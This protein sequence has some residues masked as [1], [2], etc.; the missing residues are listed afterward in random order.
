M[1]GLK[2]FGACFD[3]ELVNARGDRCKSLSAWRM[4]VVSAVIALAAIG[5]T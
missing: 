1:V 3:V 5:C 2:L 4:P